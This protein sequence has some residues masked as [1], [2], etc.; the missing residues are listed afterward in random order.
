M[1]ESNTRCGVAAIIGKPNSGKSTLLNSILDTKLSIVTP[2]PQ[3]TRKRVLGIYTN[4]FTQILFIDTPGILSP[5]YKMQEAMMDY[6]HES[7]SDAD[8]VCALLDVSKYTS[9]ESSFSA[10]FLDILRNSGKPGV[11][12]LN[13]IDLLPDVKMILPIITDFVKTGAFKEYLGISATK[14]ANIGELLDI[15]CRWMPAGEF[16]YD[17][18][19]ISSMPERFFVSEIVRETV[20]FKLKEEIPYSTEVVIT[21]FRERSK[22]KWYISADIIIEKDSQKRIMIGA[23]GEMLRTIGE[24]ARKQIENYLEREIFLELFVKVR[25]N[26]RNNENM[27]RQFGY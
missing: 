20:F 9:P 3:T 18:D 22:G 27:L 2:K 5:K 8:A 1:D 21:E 7:I 24:S 4:N 6:V 16:L 15:L 17:G 23:G 11:L 12:I 26:W 10:E 13:K 19:Y 25:N 14:K